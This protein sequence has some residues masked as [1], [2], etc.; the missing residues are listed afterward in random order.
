LGTSWSSEDM[1]SQRQAS[2]LRSNLFSANFNMKYYRSKD[3]LCISRKL[4]P[5]R[6]IVLGAQTFV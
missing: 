1:L 2:Q 4:I 3:K 6:L 5:I